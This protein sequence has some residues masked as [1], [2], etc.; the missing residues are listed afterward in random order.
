[1]RR[2]LA[3]A[4]DDPPQ[5]IECEESLVT[6][7]DCGATMVVPVAWCECGGVGWW[8]YLRCGECGHSRD[9]VVTDADARAY[10][11]ALDWGAAEIERT[12]EQL[13]HERLARQADAFTLALERDLI[14]AG[15]FAE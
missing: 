1:L 2:Y 15:D 10:E 11:R 7:P 8:M 4:R 13:D 6:C 12:L 5:G 3:R 14:D 9:V